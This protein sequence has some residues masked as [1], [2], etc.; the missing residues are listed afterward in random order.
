MIERILLILTFLAAIG[1]GVV[2]GIFFA[3]STFVM[4]ALG[5]LPPEQGIAAMNSINVSVLNPAFFLVFFGTGLVS[6]ALAASSYFSLGE[7]NGNLI[8]VAVLI[9]IVGCVGVTIV[10]NVPLNDA[11]AVAK[12]N[13][14][15]SAALWSRYLNEWTAWNHVRTF[16][17]IISAILFIATSR[18]AMS[19]RVR[20]RQP[21]KPTT[22]A[23]AC[24]V[25]MPISPSR[26]AAA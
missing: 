11:L 8:L 5:R 4:A 22:K 23:R 18:S 16:A 12:A 17:S 25:T 26:S 13:T 9:Y 19:T 15:E 7:G 3:F 20:P 24:A 10:F 6:V 14:P 2:G 1:S 21:G